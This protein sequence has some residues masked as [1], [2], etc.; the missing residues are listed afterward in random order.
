MQ[1]VPTPP[2][3]CARSGEH[4]K[5]IS[6][7]SDEERGVFLYDLSSNGTYVNGKLVGKDSRQPLKSGD[8]V[9]LLDPDKPNHYQ[10]IFQDLRPAL[11]PPAPVQLLREAGVAAGQE[12]AATP[13]PEL[14]S[15]SNVLPPPELLS[16][17]YDR[18]LLA[19]AS[20]AEE[21]LL[22]TVAPRSKLVAEPA[23]KPPA[24]PNW[25]R[26]SSSIKWIRKLGQGSFGTAYEVECGNM[27]MAA[28][29]L[30]ILVD[31]EREDKVRLL[32]REFRALNRLN[33]PFILQ[34]L[35]V[36]VDEPKSV[37]LLTELMPL[38]SL[39][40]MLDKTP[41]LIT[42]D[43]ATQLR[44]ATN[45]VSAMECAHTQGMQHHDLKSDN[46]LLKYDHEP[47]QG[48]V[49][50]LKIADFGMATG[51]GSS[52]RATKPTGAGT[53]AYTAP[54]LFK[55]GKP[56]F[57]NACDV[58]AFAICVW[59]LITGEIPWESEGEF[60]IVSALLNDERPPLK[61]SQQATYLGDMAKR[62]WVTEPD[63]RPTFVQLHREINSQPRP[64]LS[65]RQLLVFACSP[66]VSPLPEAGSEAVIVLLATSW[67]Q[68]CSIHWGGTSVQLQQALTAR[69]TRR[70]LFSGHA[71]GQ[72]KDA[73][74]V[75]T[76]SLGFTRPGAVLEIADPAVLA[77]TLGRFKQSL[78][79]VFLNGCE[80]LSLG[81][82]VCD[83][84]IPTVVCWRTK[85]ADGAARL[86]ASE[87][88]ALV[89]RG[90]SAGEAFDGA[91]KKLKNTKSQQKAGD[92]TL[93]NVQ[94]QIRD[95]KTPPAP[96]FDPLWKPWAAGLPVLI[97]KD[98]NGIKEHN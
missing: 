3:Y 80:S 92:G 61:A 60:G 23:M 72:H 5:I 31:S 81:R 59:E 17:S 47:G 19:Q 48:Q 69:K 11:P 75:V 29:K 74:G 87:F 6:S 86:F 28:K 9:T 83:Q 44:L 67:G 2:V 43:P 73:N 68:A 53:R 56:P 97:L 50:V 32:R 77:E 35:G 15:S 4:C 21:A 36:V 84:G 79:L 34:P 93:H 51:T 96:G 71:D 10:F 26:A 66:H 46:L 95:P 91:K 13:A 39:R 82:R 55:R 62:C 1:P 64:E 76:K 58:Y 40:M 14:L 85:V 90:E 25:E 12:Q 38:G 41:E 65:E 89:A 98:S 49:L 37:S 57:T 18:S 24:P 8:T 22:E 7:S 16:S 54:E 33:H 94:Y 45:I 42:S 63:R 27:A 30:E 88:F 70:F 52:T 20:T 78:E